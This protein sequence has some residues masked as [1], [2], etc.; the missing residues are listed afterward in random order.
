MKSSNEILNEMIEI[1]DKECF[2]KARVL[3]QDRSHR[4]I[5]KYPTREKVNSLL[6]T[7][8]ARHKI[9][10]HITGKKFYGLSPLIKVLSSFSEDLVIN[11]YGFVSSNV[12]GVFYFL[13]LE[14]KPLGA[15]IVDRDYSNELLNKKLFRTLND[16][17]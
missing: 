15:T 6:P 2:S 3:L 5:G 12:A 7:L 17:D 1:L 16:C 8:K 14:D 9:S 10:T 4:V 11:G 13:E